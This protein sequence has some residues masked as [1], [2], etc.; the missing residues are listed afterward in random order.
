MMAIC[1]SM[2]TQRLQQQTT[3]SLSREAGFTIIEL[4]TVIVLLGILGAYIAPKWF[5]RTD[6][7]QRGYFDEL[8]QAARYAQ[9]LAVTSGCAVHYVIAGNSL[10][11]T[12]PTTAPPSASCTSG[13]SWGTVVNLP[14]K[15]G[16]Y[17]APGGVNVGNVAL[18]FL[19][20]GQ[21]D[22][23]YTVSVT[24]TATLQFRV[25]QATGYVGRL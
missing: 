8:L 21:A 13:G 22:G 7:E 14:G 25:Y 10:S 12:Q 2:L 20:S 6:F 3:T 24:G 9:K 15:A 1:N 16:P 4:V 5:N 11:L 23:T 18:T 17:N 19:P